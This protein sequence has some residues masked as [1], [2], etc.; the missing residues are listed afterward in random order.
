MGDSPRGTT[1]SGCP[2]RPRAIQPGPACSILRARAMRVTWQAVASRSDAMTDTRTKAWEAT[3][4][5]GRMD[6]A[7][8]KGRA[9]AVAE[10]SLPLRAAPTERGEKTFE[11]FDGKPTAP[12]AD[13]GNGQETGPLPWFAP[14]VA[15]GPVRKINSRRYAALA[16]GPRIRSRGVHPTRLKPHHLWARSVGR[17]GTWKRKQ[18]PS[19][20]RARTV[21][22]A[23]RYNTQGL[24]T[25]SGDPAC[26]LG[27]RFFFRDFPCAQ[28]NSR[29]MERRSTE[30]AE[31]VPYPSGGR[32][33]LRR[34][35]S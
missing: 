16:S 17:G 27:G 6:Q 25:T 31:R 8:L 21:Q 34:E 35:A 13:R 24:F 19:A 29:P 2:T 14:T 32:R 22:V 33:A 30:A 12:R 23:H 5:H 4:A 1:W 11:V 3:L 18:W 26:K 28:I 10:P 20:D 15:H 7:V 9:S